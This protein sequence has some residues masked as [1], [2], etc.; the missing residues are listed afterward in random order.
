MNAKQAPEIFVDRKEAADTLREVSVFSRVADEP[1]WEH[2]VKKEMF[3]WVV[4]YG[5]ALLVVAA[6]IG[7]VVFVSLRG[8]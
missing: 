2:L 7:F 4:L 3:K 5:G 6:V 8:Q 1:N